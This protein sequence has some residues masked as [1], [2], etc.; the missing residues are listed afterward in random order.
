MTIKKNQINHHINAEILVLSCREFK[1]AYYG[2]N[3]SSKN[4]MPYPHQKCIF[5]LFVISTAQVLD[6]SKLLSHF[7]ILLN[8][9]S[10]SY[11]LCNISPVVR[12]LQLVNDDRRR[13]P[14]TIK[15]PCT[16]TCQLPG[17]KRDV[18]Q[19][20]CPSLITHINAATLIYAPV[21][22][23]ITHVNAATLIYAPVTSPITHVNAATLIYAPVTSLITHVNA[24]TLIDT[25]VKM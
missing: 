20:G 8:K 16:G 15:M 12:P 4:S 21:P 17:S 9:C 11:M 13:C 10:F 3:N 5:K 6:W 23:L 2:L 22:S 7:I 24:A 19:L 1:R 18:S 25:R 14:T